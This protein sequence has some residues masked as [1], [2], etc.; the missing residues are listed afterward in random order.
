MAVDA[1]MPRLSYQ[2][3]QAIYANRRNMQEGSADAN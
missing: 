1:M 2:A 3:Q